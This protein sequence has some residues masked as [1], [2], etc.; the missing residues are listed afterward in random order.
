MTEISC[1]VGISSSITLS[2][3]PW[4]LLKILIV[5]DRG[6]SWKLLYDFWLDLQ[7]HETL[8]QRDDSPLVSQAI[9]E[10]IPKETTVLA[11]SNQLATSESE[12]WSQCVSALN[13]R[14]F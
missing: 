1:G 9:H 3:D 7:Q 8:Q 13:L 2:T 10:S 14:S 5:Q 12:K 6:E 11:S 4:S